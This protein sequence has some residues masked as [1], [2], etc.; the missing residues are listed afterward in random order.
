MLA[1][2]PVPIQLAYLAASILFIV[3][4]K[5]LSSPAQARM[6]NQIA[7]ASMVELLGVLIGSVSFSGSIVAWGKLQGVISEK[8]IAGAW[9]RVLNIAIVI[10]I[11]I[12][13]FMT[14]TGGGPGRLTV[15]LISA[16]AFG[17]F[18]VI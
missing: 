10:A 9:T 16:L 18:M 6:G 1:E 15:F 2:I 5:F 11:V 8:A 14:L 17:I 7:A 3:G 13:G 12:S 4:L